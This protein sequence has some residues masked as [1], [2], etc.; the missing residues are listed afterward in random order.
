MEKEM[1]ILGRIVLT[2]VAFGAYWAVNAT[3]S[4]VA[5]LQ[6]AAVATKQLE[7]SDA[8][9]IASSYGI[10]FIGGVHTLFSFALLVVLVLIW[11]KPGVA[12]WKKLSEEDGRGTTSVLV[13]LAAIG[14]IVV[15][16]PSKAYAYAGTSDKKEYARIE[17]DET[18]FM[19]PNFGANLDS[20]AQYK[21]DYL[22]QAGVKVPGKFINIPHVKLNGTGGDSGLASVFGS[23]YYVNSATLVRVKRTQYSRVWTK[24]G[25]GTNKQLDESFNCQTKDGLNVKHIGVAII[26]LIEDEN[27]ALYLSKFG[28]M[29]LKGKDDLTLIENVFI[30]VREARSL[31]E[32]TDD[33]AY[34][35]V[36]QLVCKYIAME[37]DPEV[38]SGHMNEIM[39]NVTKDL[40]VYLKNV[41]ISLK[42]LGWSDAWDFDE[43]VQI[44]MNQKFNARMVGGSLE[45]LERNAN[46]NLKEGLGVG[47]RNKMPSSLFLGSPELLG[48][49][50]SGTAARN[51]GTTTVQPPK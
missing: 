20:Q 48:V 14:V 50:A 42:S 16:Q 39:G 1:S 47:F 3:Y 32:V 34:T 17:P 24:Q 37:D 13:L 30:S 40:E 7:N 45:I 12:A 19:I 6:S 38:A 18:A 8:A 15:L 31:V 23:D 35:K 51:A 26:D 21:P 10:Q 33:V 22:N 49:A 36:H 11:W 5:A 46:I 29:A 28:L 2:V 9:F 25:R 4:P 44:A 41:G 43:D 27:S